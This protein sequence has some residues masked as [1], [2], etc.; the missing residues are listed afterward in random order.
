MMSA[1]GPHA[2]FIVAAYAVAV[3]VLLSL[4]VWVM[5]DRRQLA[6]SLDDLQ[7]RGINRRSQQ[8]K[9]P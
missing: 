5:V 7:A 2:G 6:R 1:L 3:V 4:V 9:Q 8:G